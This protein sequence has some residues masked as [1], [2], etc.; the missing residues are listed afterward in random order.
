MSARD[1]K[2]HESWTRC[3]HKEENIQYTRGFCKED[4]K[5][6]NKKARGWT[7]IPIRYIFLRNNL[8]KNAIASFLRVSYSTWSFCGLSQRFT[9]FILAVTREFWFSSSFEILQKRLFQIF[10]ILRKICISKKREKIEKYSEF[11]NHFLTYAFFLVYRINL[12]GMVYT[13]WNAVSCL[14]PNYLI[15]FRTRC[16]ELLKIEYTDGGCTTWT[17]MENK[18]SIAQKIWLYFCCFS[19]ISRNGELFLLPF[20]F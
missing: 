6:R 18:I 12:C 5:D 1:V 4:K 17:W 9:G 13:Y 2:L 15:T 20:D 14:Q 11:T 8:T 19:V 7:W 10:Q 16:G 3:R